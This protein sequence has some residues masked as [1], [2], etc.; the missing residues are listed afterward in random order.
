M[1][2][3][4]WDEEIKLID[5]ALYEI[6]FDQNFSSICLIGHPITDMSV[7]SIIEVLNSYESERKTDNV[8]T[9][10]SA[11]EEFQNSQRF[12]E[13]FAEYEKEERKQE[14]EWKED[15]PNREKRGKHLFDDIDNGLYFVDWEKVKFSRVK[16]LWR[17]ANGRGK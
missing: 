1:Q 13:Q 8:G 3:T 16:K 12:Q 14:K 4:S 6:D 7:G 5:G 2:A 10:I 9:K 11:A 15:K 17:K